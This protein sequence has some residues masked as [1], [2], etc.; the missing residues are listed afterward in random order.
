MSADP[1]GGH[2]GLPRLF[3]NVRDL[4]LLRVE[5]GADTIH[6][7]HGF[8]AVLSDAGALVWI[9]AAG[10]IVGERVDSS[11]QRLSEHL[12]AAKVLAGLRHPLSPPCLVLLILDL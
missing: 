9:V 11:L 4:L 8:L 12:T 2:A 7:G 6:F 10:E 1:T 5:I 3:F